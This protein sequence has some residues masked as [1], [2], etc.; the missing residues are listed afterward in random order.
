MNHTV[1]TAFQRL[2]E[3]VS[4]VASFAGQSVR[5]SVDIT[6]VTV[7]WKRS[8][9]ALQLYSL[10]CVMTLDAMSDVLRSLYRKW[11]CK[12]A[13]VAGLL[14][15]TAANQDASERGWHF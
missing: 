15:A 5:F 9:L 8:S 12:G 4:M 11:V 6:P 7:Q 3:S 1:Q 14:T 2:V 10:H 13:S